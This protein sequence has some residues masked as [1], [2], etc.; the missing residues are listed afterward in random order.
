MPQ[1]RPMPTGG[2]GMATPRMTP[3]VPG[4]ADLARMTPRVPAGAGDMTAR[5]MAAAADAN[6]GGGKSPQITIAQLLPLA[7]DQLMKLAKKL[8]HLSVMLEQDTVVSDTAY[9]TFAR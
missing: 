3:R 9:P 7:P 1:P 4:S 2:D 8:V 5:R 6:G